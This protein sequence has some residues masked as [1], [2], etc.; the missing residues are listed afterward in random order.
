MMT[1]TPRPG[2]ETTHNIMLQ[3]LHCLDGLEYL[4][5]GMWHTLKYE[6]VLKYEPQSVMLDDFKSDIITGS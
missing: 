3:T 4:V 1:S 5:F 6:D 2:P